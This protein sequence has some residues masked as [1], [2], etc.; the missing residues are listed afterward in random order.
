MK[1]IFLTLTVALFALLQPTRAQQV[2]DMVLE[3]ATRTVNN[4]TSNYTQV[5]IAQFKKTA[6]TY[7]RQQA[8][9]CDTVVHS[10][11][12]DYQAYYLN[13][14]I[15]SYLKQ[16]INYSG[17][18][19]K[20]MRQNIIRLFIK[21]SLDCPMWNDPDT[22]TRQSYIGGNEEFTPFSLDTDWQKAY[23]ESQLLL[24]QLP[25]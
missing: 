15:T 19:Q 21:S 23:E 10:S 9:Q 12:L 25:Q 18:H 16:I 2:Y 13:L 24:N 11:V 7:M 1:K 17:E 3:S 14:F 22:E 8:E 6:L 20:G 5:Q 4:P